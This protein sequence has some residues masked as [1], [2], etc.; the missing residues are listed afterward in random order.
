MPLYPYDPFE[1]VL[2]ELDEQYT[3]LNGNKKVRMF[4]SLWFLL[5]F[6]ISFIGYFVNIKFCY[7]QSV[8]T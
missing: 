3:D 2:T 5:I 8:V 7:N 1:D 6:I 4:L